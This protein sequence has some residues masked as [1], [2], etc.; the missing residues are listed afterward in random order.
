MMS[1]EYPGSPPA[2]PMG[3]PSGL[4]GLPRPQAQQ[5]SPYFNVNPSY[6]QTP[7]F[8]VNQDTKKGRIER[9]FSGIGG[10]VLAGAAV[11]GAYGLYDGVRQTAAAGMKGSLRR[12]QILNYTTKS[13]ASVSNALGSLAVIYSSLHALGS[14]ALDYEEDDELKCIVTAGITGA[15]YKS[16]AGAVKSAT[17]AAFGIG[18]GAVWSFLLKRN[19][20]VSYYV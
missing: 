7:E 18:L 10:S 13:G 20:T 14:Y 15:L 2:P 16:S 1:E 8:I 6:V 5:L 17:G 11:G 4:L 9:S 19:E 12:T 3:A